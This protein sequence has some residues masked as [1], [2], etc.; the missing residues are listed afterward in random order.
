MNLYVEVALLLKKHAM[1]ATILHTKRLPSYWRLSFYGG[2]LH[3]SYGHKAISQHATTHSHSD[4]G[5]P[6]NSCYTIN[7]SIMY[8]SRHGTNGQ[9]TPGLLSIIT[10]YWLGPVDCQLTV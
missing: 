6:H 9:A 4:P 10:C 3:V 8:S 5:F 7:M 2:A 1:F